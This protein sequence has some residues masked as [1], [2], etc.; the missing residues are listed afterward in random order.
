MLGKI[1]RNDL[2]NCFKGTGNI[3]KVMSSNLCHF[4][5][6]NNIQ[7][8]FAKVYKNLYNSVDDQYNLRRR[9]KISKPISTD[10]KGS[11]TKEA[12]TSTSI[13]LN[14]GKSDSILDIS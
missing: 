14:P 4:N 13:K 8:H 1:K 2:L 11:L 12:L 6:T 7:M 3:G 9:K 5:V 10:L